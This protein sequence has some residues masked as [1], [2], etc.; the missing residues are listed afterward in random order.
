VAKKISDL[1][2][3]ATRAT[4][5]A[6]FFVDCFYRGKNH[7]KSCQIATFHQV[8]SFNVAVSTIIHHPLVFRKKIDWA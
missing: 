6:M 1:R 2:L 7:I 4:L 5:S 3:H 8:N